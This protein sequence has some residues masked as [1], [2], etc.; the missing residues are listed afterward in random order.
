MR[1]LLVLLALLAP[2][3]AGP[4]RFAADRPVDLVHLRLDATVVLEERLLRAVATLELRALRTVR[5]VTL[6]AEGLK[7]SKVEWV[8]GATAEVPCRND[9]ASLVITPPAPFPAEARAV[10]R[11]HYEVRDPKA[12]LR[13][14]GPTAAQPEVP[15][16]VWSQGETTDNR[17]WIPCFDHPNDRFTSELAITAGKGL[18]ILSNG[19]MEP[20]RENA[21]GTVTWHWKQEHDHVAYLI[22]L[23]VGTFAVKEES[24]RG[25]PVTYWV[26][27]KREADIDRSF[28]NTRRMLDLFSE[29]IGVEYPWAQYAQV[30][31]EQFDFGGMENTSATTLHE[32]TLHDARAHLD[33]RSEGLVAHELA[34]QWFGDL[35][36]CRDWAH[37]WL[38]EGFAS[39]FEAIWDEHDEG[40]DALA[41][42]M[43]RKGRA[44]IAG[45]RAL[46]IVHR[47]Y[48]GEWEQFDARAYPKGAWV[49]HMLRRRVGD[50]LFWRSVRRYVETNRHRCVET[51]DL[52]KAF[53]E[54]TGR[55]LERF[56]HDWTER[57]GHPVVQVRFAWNAERRLGEI[58]VTQ[59]QKEEAFHF[60]FAFEVRFAEG[61]PLL[62]SHDVDEKSERFFFDC[63]AAP[64]L[65]RVDPGTTV[66]MELK[67]SKG[68]DLLLAQLRDDPDPA[69]RIRAAEQLAEA[70]DAAP[71]AEALRTERFWAV[72]GEIA[73]ALGRIGGD[74]ARDALLP[75]LAI[76]EARARKPVVQA[77]A[78]FRDDAAVASALERIVREGDPSYGVEAAAITAW[79]GLRPPGAMELLGACLA[80][81]SHNEEIRC[82]A[83]GG[84]GDQLDPSAV[85][86]LLP[87]TERGR[88][89]EC[90]AAALA[91]LSKASRTGDLTEEALR[92][93]VAAA[94]PCLSRP[95]HKS[96]KNAASQL[97]RDL[98]AAAAPAIPALDALASHDAAE[99]VR[100][101]A[102]AA[103]E[104]IRAGSPANLELQRL[105]EE[106]QK[107]RD[108]NQ[109]LSDRIDR[110][111]RKAPDGH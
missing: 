107:L 110:L 31:V 3:S 14:F 98:G 102:K 70:R 68:R 108:R 55:S 2:L 71:L 87:W 49:L 41:W 11:I 34:H 51:V 61:A 12:G 90:R 99:P 32:S 62:L 39:Y 29:K 19:R 65:L 67:E 91:A 78:R 35:V 88:P 64:A 80:R 63:P 101:E 30:C 5:A 43:V 109:A 53:E 76:G 4:L 105:R 106:L 48:D 15:W 85:D 45:G 36:T 83:L 8:A 38:N 100:N 52:R 59:T 56:F 111:E 37:V 1:R 77:L 95:E 54:T 79:A 27:P 26:A 84:L 94:I 20:P 42:N 69:A 21:D 97:L 17:H 23:V 47:A 96:V 9:G 28:A 6:D 24:W 75:A 74:A 93:V 60:P 13:F 82:A 58:E 57:P 50:D 25:R 73:A 22:T 81:E 104:R 44:A 10:L 72:Q 16:Q 86:R 18:R 103:V 40:A 7:V 46:P 33:F 66:L 89:R 92:R